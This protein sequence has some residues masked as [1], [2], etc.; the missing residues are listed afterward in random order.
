MILTNKT[1]YRQITGYL[2]TDCTRYNISTNADKQ[3]DNKRITALYQGG[4]YCADLK[5]DHIKKESTIKCGDQWVVTDR[6]FTNWCGKPLHPNNPYKWLKRLCEKESESFK[7]L[8]SFRHFVATQA[9]A[10]GAATKDVSDLLGHANPSVTLNVYAHTVEPTND[11][12]LN[13]VANLLDDN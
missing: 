8:H 9:L 2:Q 10:N 13:M 12:T 3:K 1:Q 5:T 4:I 7:G 6:L 11:K